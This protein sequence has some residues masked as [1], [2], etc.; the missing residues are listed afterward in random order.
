MTESKSTRRRQRAR[1]A[2]VTASLLAAVAA[3]LTVLRAGSWPVSESV[4]EHLSL[5][6]LPPEFRRSLGTILM[7]PIGSLVVVFVRLTLGLRMLGPFRPILIAIGLRGAGALTGLAF[8]VLV[9]AAITWI[10]PRLRG[11]M[12]PYYGRLSVLLSIVVLVEVA[13][14][15][16]GQSLQIDAMLRTAYFPIVVLTLAADGFAR[17]LAEEGKRIAIGRGGVTIGTALA[18]VGV[19]AASSLDRITLARPEI[20][21]VETAAIIVVSSLADFRLLEGIGSRF[22]RRPPRSKPTRSPRERT[23]GPPPR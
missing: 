5:A 23:P 10:R 22:A 4:R 3:A 17:A 20:L 1:R 7:V 2:L 21:L 19:E 12:L 18:I 15:L 14:L 11:G 6:D 9:L 16:A 8:F 13:V